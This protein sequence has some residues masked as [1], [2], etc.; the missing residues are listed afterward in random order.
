MPCKNHPFVEDRLTRCSRCAEAFCPDCIVEI[1]GLPYCLSCKTESMRDLRS[2]V[3]V[4]VL[5]MASIG[6]RFVAIFIDGLIVTIPII[7]LIFLVFLPLGLLKAQAGMEEFPPALAIF[8]NIFVSFMGAAA[9]I[10]YEGLM[11]S[12]GG[13]TVG[14]KAM[15]VKVVTAEG[16]Q[17]T[18]GQ[19][20]GRA[21]S[22]QILGIVPCLGLID[23]L[24]AFG[25][26]RTTIHDMM[27]KTR[28]VNSE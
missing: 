24:V 12:S 9:Y 27:A 15:S 4:G 10:L 17:L 21:A 22:R 2:G 14:K 19:A 6:R 5:D 25:Q 16:S 8:G 20:W 26:E 28:V 18:T 11:L 3:P 23:Y 13:Q 1:G 7:A